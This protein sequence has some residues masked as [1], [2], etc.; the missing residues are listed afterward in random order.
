VSAGI[1]ERDDGLSEKDER[2]EDLNTLHRQTV[3]RL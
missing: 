2:E 3:E 1:R